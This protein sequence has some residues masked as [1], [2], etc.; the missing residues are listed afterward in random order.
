MTKSSLCSTSPR[1]AHLDMMR[2]LAAIAVVVGHIRGFVLVDF[3]ALEHTSIWQKALYFA[4]GQGHQAVIAFFALSGFLVG[5]NALELLLSGR[6]S[7]FEYATARLSRLWTVLIPALALTLTMDVIGAAFGG[8]QGYRG[9]YSHLLSS[10]PTYDQPADHSVT[11]LLANLVFLQT[12]IRPVYGTN[13]PLWSL[14]YEFWYYV[15]FPLAAWALLTPASRWA[16]G[17]SLVCAGAIAI[18]LPMHIMIL[19]ILWVAGALAHGATLRL[20]WRTILASR[21]YAVGAGVLVVAG[22]VGLRKGG[23]EADLL[24]GFAWVALL[25]ALAA[26]KSPGVFY[27]R[28]AQGVS[29]ISF[30]LYVVHFPIL[31][32]IYF[33]A[34]APVQLQPGALAIL[35]MA[36]LLAVVL[37]SA[38]ALWWCFERNT[39]LV[40]R[41]IRTVVP[42]F[43]DSYGGRGRHQS[44][45]QRT[46]LSLGIGEEDVVR[47]R[48]RTSS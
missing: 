48:A 42:L 5:G 10:G 2:G 28:L 19:G 36:G 4:S 20:Q 30:T 45:A 29:E 24:L 7:I 43:A 15:V 6:W 11:T 8:E 34:M 47:K 44:E 46:D 16:R 37:G 38:T 40:R 33:V 27:A 35:L 22:L 23:I 17:T 32:A 25:P 39:F 9:A 21:Y 1:L 18:M 41:A 14:A 26:L 31:A 3:A 13:G 12:I